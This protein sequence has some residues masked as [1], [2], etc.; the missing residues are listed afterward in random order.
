[1]PYPLIRVQPFSLTP[2]IGNVLDRNIMNRVN[3]LVITSPEIS[4]WSSCSGDATTQRALQTMFPTMFLPN[5]GLQSMLIS[6][7]GITLCQILYTTKTK[8]ECHTVQSWSGRPMS[9]QLVLCFLQYPHFQW[10][11]R[12][13]TLM[14]TTV[15]TVSV[16]LLML[17]TYMEGKQHLN[18]SCRIE[19]LILCMCPSLV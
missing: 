10:Y 6:L 8:P 2:A 16:C 7:S 14:C 3:Y 13:W 5:Q 11:A 15:K 1:M 4:T 9:T 18:A 12:Q 17:S 19:M